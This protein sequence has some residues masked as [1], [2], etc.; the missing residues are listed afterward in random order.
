MC[1]A[2]VYSR[3]LLL[4]LYSVHCAS[5]IAI[6]KTGI[7]EVWRNEQTFMSRAHFRVNGREKSKKSERVDSIECDGVWV[8]KDNRRK[9]KC[10]TTSPH[11][12]LL[13]C[14]M[15][16]DSFF[17]LIFGPFTHFAILLPKFCS[18]YLYVPPA[19]LLI[20]I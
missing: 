7:K 11:I 4:L 19:L 10:G 18:R 14:E 3:V 17:V 12:T 5:A 16:R 13:I 1:I 6:C 9:R 2:V 15:C 20:V 8:D